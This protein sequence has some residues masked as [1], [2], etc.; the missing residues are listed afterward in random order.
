M[1]PASLGDTTLGWF[2]KLSPGKI[3]N[4]KELDEQFT[5]R[6]ITN[7]WV[8]KGPKSLTHL[9][10]KQRETLRKYSQRYWELF[11]ETEYCD[12]KFTVGTFKF[13]L[14]WDSND[15]YNDLP[16]TFDDLLARVDEFSK[17]D[18]DDRAAIRLNVKRDRGNDRR[19]Q[20]FKKEEQKG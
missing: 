9:K 3:D 4:F 18:D 14:P 17:V 16:R 10:K 2:D 1:F 20:G 6:F 8:V 15:I 13:G 19:K 12:L 11:Q 5:A 7:S